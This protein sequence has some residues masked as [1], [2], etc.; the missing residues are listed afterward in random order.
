MPED[1][2]RRREA[3]NLCGLD[4]ST[5]PQA[6]KFRTHVVAHADPVEDRVAD[7]KYR[8]ASAHGGAYEDH[9]VEER[10]CAPDFREAL[11]GYV[12]LAA[13]VAFDRADDKPYKHSRGR[14]DYAEE[15][16]YAHPVHD[17]GVD[18]ASAGVYAEGMRLAG[19]ER[20]TYLGGGQDAFGDGRRLL[21]LHEY[22]RIAVALRARDVVVGLVDVLGA[23]VVPDRTVVAEV[24][25]HRL[26]VVS[27]LHDRLAVLLQSR[28]VHDSP[29]I[30]RADH[31]GQ[32]AEHE[33]DSE[34]YQRPPCAADAL[35]R[36]ESLNCK[37]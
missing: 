1:D 14:K 10:H 8:E 27:L 26:Y 32:H 7:E 22:A 36:T 23:F 20:K 18:V 15:Q 4:E 3:L 11:E 21:G 25:A 33:D 9:D 2:A 28:R 37:R 6:Q 29:W 17:A 34:P 5:R 13:E 12:D 31:V 24:V 19:T 35:E 16:R 30:A